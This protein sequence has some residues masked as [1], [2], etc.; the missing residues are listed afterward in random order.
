MTFRS[1]TMGIMPFPLRR[2]SVAALSRESSGF[3]CD[4]GRISAPTGAASEKVVS[5]RGRESKA[6]IVLTPPG[7]MNGLIEVMK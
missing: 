2:S 7:R 1:S 3:R 5:S 4:D 6:T